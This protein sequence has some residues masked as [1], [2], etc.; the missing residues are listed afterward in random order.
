MGE[1]EG[2][3]SWWTRSLSK[4]Q[5]TEKESPLVNTA[6]QL[7]S[8]LS[9]VS[10]KILLR[11]WWKVQQACPPHWWAQEV[12]TWRHLTHSWSVLRTRDQ[13]SESKAL[14]WA[15]SLPTG[16]VCIQ[17]LLLD[18]SFIGILEGAK[19]L[20]SALWGVYPPGRTCSIDSALP[21][22]NLPGALESRCGGSIMFSRTS[23]AN[24]GVEHKDK[25]KSTMKS[26]LGRRTSQ[27]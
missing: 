4:G 27:D 16:K 5:A 6:G 18:V 20:I 21:T 11:T 17:R 24:H 15:A 1:N 8:L 22:W 23:A 2:Q 12:Q 7:Q 3:E 26:E 9:S 13:N 10:S 19:G 14:S 25:D